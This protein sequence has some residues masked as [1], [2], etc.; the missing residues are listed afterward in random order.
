MSFRYTIIL[1]KK[2]GKQLTKLK[3]NQVL[4]KKILTIIDELCID[5][6]SKLHKF[7]RLIGNYSGFCSKRIDQ[8]NRIIYQVIDQKVTIIIVSVHGH[9]NDN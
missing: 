8:K 7:E 6:Y 4:I 9:Y 1:D 2:A 3:N 5:P